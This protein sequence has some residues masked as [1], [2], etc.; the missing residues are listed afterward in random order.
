[1]TDPI[2]RPTRRLTFLIG[3]PEME[4]GTAAIGDDGRLTIDV[5]DAGEDALRELLIQKSA[6]EQIVDGG[7]DGILATFV[8]AAIGEHL[9]ILMAYGVNFHDMYRRTAT[10]VDKILKGAKPADLPVEQPTRFYLTINLE[11]AKAIGITFPQSVLLRA[12]IVIE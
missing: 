3:P 6:A 5:G 8:R 11:T 12:D 9:A 7:T 10:Y 1:M 4:D 2:Y